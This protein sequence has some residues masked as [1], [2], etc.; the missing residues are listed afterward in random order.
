MKKLTL[1]A[2]TVSLLLAM[3]A[4][5]KQ[6]QTEPTIGETSAAAPTTQPTEETTIP[7]QTEPEWVEGIARAAHAEA[8]KDTLAKE[9]KVNVLGRYLDYLVIEGEEYNLLV[10]ERFVRLETEEAFESTVGYARQGAKV[11][12]SV[13]LRGEPIAKL[14]INTKLTIVE[15]K[16][17]WA[18]VSWDNGEGYV[19]AQSISK[20]YLRSGSGS[21]NG[22]SGGSN[23][24]TDVNTGLLSAAKSGELTLLGAYY[25]PE[26]EPDFTAGQ[27]TILA[28]D[29]EAYL[30]LWDRGDTV[31]VTASDEE[32]CTIWIEGELFVT[33]P[34][35]LVRLVEDEAY[36]SWTGYTRYQASAYQ[37]YQLRNC[38]ATPTVNTEVTVLDELAAGSYC[39]DYPGCYV[40]QIGEEIYYMSLDD[41]S[42]YRFA[43]GGGKTGSGGST[44]VWTPPAL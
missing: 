11:F 6:P 23:D 2:L 37:E 24:G 40:V 9:T 43:T 36:E 28:D 38:G 26:M 8:L 16:G 10:E 31:K 14:S 42:Q 29:V 12:E 35:Y 33:L 22:N 3:V 5:G 41:V 44:D 32:T 30:L 13:Y 27:G 39:Y 34:R 18:Y 20:Y 25:G 17:N 4:C 21:G 7:A 19:D 15:S 1:L